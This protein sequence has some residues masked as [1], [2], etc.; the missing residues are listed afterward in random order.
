MRVFAAGTAE[1]EQGTSPHNTITPQH[2]DEVVQVRSSTEVAE[3]VRDAATRGRVVRPQATGHGAGAAVGPGETIVDTSGM[4]SIEIDPA[5]RLARVGAGALWGSVNKAAE[6][7]GLL[8]LAGSAPSVSVSGYT[9][10]GGLGWLSTPAGLASAHLRRVDYVDGTGRER[11]AAEDADDELDR[12][13]LFVFRGGGG[14]GVATRLELDLVEVQDLHAGLLLWPAAHLADVVGAW[15]ATVGRVGA[16]T[17]TSIGVLHAP[18]L[19]FIP[20]ELHG[21]PVVH[22]AVADHEG[23]GGAQVLL[24]AVRA[25]TT[26]ALD[27]WGPADVA[28]LGGI[29]LDPPSGVPAVGD[30]RWL[31]AGGAAAVAAILGVAVEDGSPL[32]MVE[33]RSTTATASGVDGAFTTAPGPFL[34]HAVGSPSGE[35]ARS[36]LDAAFER[37]RQAGGPYDV[38]VE[39]GSWMEGA[40]ATPGALPSTVRERARAI[41]DRVDPDRVV[42]RPRQLV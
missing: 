35:S 27:T 2:P 8:G 5:A 24:D 34:W 13:A 11:V 32:L 22:L 20:A 37:V 12:E 33:V 38:G 42:A 16:A 26:P 6:G 25:A 40:A 9:F 14:V 30:A 18:P 1:Y 4:D 31:G 28:K 15:A 41:A 10:G 39:M 17:A 19:P 7:H 21:T 29:H 36:E 23:G 3:A